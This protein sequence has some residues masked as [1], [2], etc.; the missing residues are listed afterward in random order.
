MA[1]QQG[2]GQI[3]GGAAEHVGED[4]DPGALV[5][6]LGGIIQT[7]HGLGH[8]LG[9]VHAD[10]GAVAQGTKDE[11]RR[12]QHGRAIV[13]MGDNDDADLGGRLLFRHDIPRAGTEISAK[14][15]T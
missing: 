13:G 6:P 14:C 7:A 8:F 3:G 10:G 12:A 4:D 15:S 11:L 9:D 5:Q 1:P 2:E